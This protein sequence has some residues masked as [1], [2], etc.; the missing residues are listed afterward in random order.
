MEIHMRTLASIATVT[1]LAATLSACGTVDPY[2]PNNYPVSSTSTT[3]PSTYPNAVVTSNVTEFGRVSNI[4]LVAANTVP[5]S[6]NSTAG[7][8]IGGVVG[9]ALGNTI[10]GGSGRAAATIL[11][12]VGG[13]VVGNKIAQNRDGTYDSN[14]YRISVQTDNGVWRSYDV[15]AT[16]DLRVGDRVRIENNV[17]YRA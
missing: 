3:Y 13:A 8:I 5:R 9:A 10:G 16:G 14:V 4:E 17:L 7:T 2:G 6:N 12:A 11:G 1:V 15:A